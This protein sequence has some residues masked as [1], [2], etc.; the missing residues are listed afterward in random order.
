MS[1]LAYWGLLGLVV[2]VPLPL[3]ADRPLPWSAMALW[4]GLLLVLW[5]I[6]AARRRSEHGRAADRYLLP[7]AAVFGLAI[8]WLVF[9]TIAPA[10][11]PLLPEAARRAAA[12]L[13]EA[14]PPGLGLDA[15]AAWTTLMRILA[16]GGVAF[17]GWEYGR[18]RA[19][20]QGLVWATL[21]ATA[22]Y[23][24]YGLVVQLAGLNTVLWF[25]KTA[26]HDSVTGPFINRNSF[27]TY[28]GIG[29]AAALGLAASRWLR[30]PT[31][32][33]VGS[34]TAHGDLG[35]ALLVLVVAL[36]AVTL[37]MTRSRG[38]FYSFGLAVLA[39]GIGLAA[40]G[41]LRGRRLALAILGGGAA[42]VAVLAAGGSGLATRLETDRISIEGS[43]GD[44][45]GPTLAAIGQRPL[46][47]YGL[48]SFQGVFEAGN[49]GAL[50][51]HGYNL[52]KA[53]NTYLELALEGGIPVAAAL[54][55][56]VLA[57]AA[58]CLLA[59]WRRRSIV[60]GLTGSVA[61][62][63]VGVHALVDF[64]LQ[65]PAVAVTFLALLGAC[66]AQCRRSLGE[67]PQS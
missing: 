45:F 6:F 63:G 23:A 2:L 35:L 48:G 53:H 56:C 55:G 9:Q 13:D 52:D 3:A 34:P 50:Y 57:L 1:R 18:R 43:R 46:L 59:L 24:V 5:A 42:L 62:I 66:A 14:P 25:A 38:G 39:G 51:R 49:D 60:F 10:P 47:G 36:L 58:P 65:M 8:A 44:I 26:Y 27:A 17:L 20:A 21:A 16:Y 30:R 29:L 67:P 41:A 15:D 28:I 19:D 32:H 40:S 64:S 12:L 31:R 37:V 4:V 54:T 33:R 7:I 61:A 11:P 22:I